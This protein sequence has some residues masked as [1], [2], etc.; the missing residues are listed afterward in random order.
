MKEDQHLPSVDFASYDKS[1]E[2]THNML[3][4]VFM[5]G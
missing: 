2:G 5:R 4:D 1:K 3:A